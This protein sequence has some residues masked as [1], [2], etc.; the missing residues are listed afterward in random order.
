MNLVEEIWWEKSQ[1]SQHSSCGT[2]LLLIAA[3]QVYSENHEQ[4]AEQKELKSL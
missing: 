2:W 4:K 3:S 1:G